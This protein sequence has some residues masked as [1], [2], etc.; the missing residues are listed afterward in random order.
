VR[1]YTS[2][3]SLQESLD[4]LLAYQVVEESGFS[5]ALRA[6]DGNDGVVYSRS[7]NA[8]FMDEIDDA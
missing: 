4:S 6:H 7:L 3:Y 5:R 8:R 2:V 1:E